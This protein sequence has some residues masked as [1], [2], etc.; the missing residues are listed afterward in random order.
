MPTR[1]CLDRFRS[2][3]ALCLLVLMLL[4]PAILAQGSPKCGYCGKAI[5][6]SYIQYENRLYHPECYH[7][8]VAPKC[9]FC[10][11]PLGEKWVVHDSKNYHQRCFD[12]NVAL[13]CSV[14]GG[15]IEGEYLLD[16]WGNKYHK[17]HEDEIP[18][19]SFC[20]RL[21][22]D[23]LAGQGQ[24]FGRKHHICASCAAESVSDEP[25]GRKLLDETRDR[26]AD[27]GVSIEQDKIG[28][29]LVSQ[30]KLAQLT[31]RDSDNHFG[32][33]RYEYTR[34]LGLF[35]NRE[36]TIYILTGLPKL[37][38]ISAAAHELMHVWLLTNTRQKTEEQLVEGSCNYA[39]ALVLRQYND[40]MA[41]YVIKQMDDEPDVIYGEGFRRV[42]KMADNRGV[43]YW[44]QHLRLDPEFPIGY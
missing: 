12:D 17:Y 7:N 30:E 5:S 13:K 16:Y 32:L 34:F 20:G 21:F 31:G 18:S 38:F 4:G 22:S 29:E 33:T 6:G 9:A 8:N 40:E 37:H 26:L 27:A 25:L 15:I 36:Y 28:F 19:C 14:C 42:K 11:K 23:P 3:A 41:G 10:G 2:L 39:A 35:E 1:N 44:L 43:E 24:A